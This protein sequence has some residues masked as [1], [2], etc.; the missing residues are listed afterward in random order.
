[1]VSNFCLIGKIHHNFLVPRMIELGRQTFM[2]IQTLDLHRVLVTSKYNGERQ[3][4]V[5]VSHKTAVK[6]VKAE[7]HFASQNI[8]LFGNPLHCYLLLKRTVC[9][10]LACYSLLLNTLYPSA[11]FAYWNIFLL[12]TFY[13]PTPFAS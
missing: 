4:K 1:M 13:S 3:C 7:A 2:P 8:L 9:F 10:K 11:L 5:R 12:G 6:Q